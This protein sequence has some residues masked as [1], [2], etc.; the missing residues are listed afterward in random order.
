MKY[1][2]L[3]LDWRVKKKFETWTETLLGLG[4]S[5]SGSIFK[6]FYF[7]WQMKCFNILKSW[8]KVPVNDTLFFARGLK[9]WLYWAV[10]IQP[11]NLLVI[12]SI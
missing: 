1:R 12:L 6:V 8:C 3:I 9:V 10:V 7:E 11:C 2:I 5:K 4:N